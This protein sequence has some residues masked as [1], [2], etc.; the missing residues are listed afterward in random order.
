MLFNT[1]TFPF[2][3]EG[4]EAARAW[5][6]W[7]MRKETYK[8]SAMLIS[9]VAIIAISSGATAASMGAVEDSLIKAFM[10]SKA[11]GL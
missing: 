7:Y 5:K 8:L 9:Y 2:T 1:K 6:P 10:S 4:M 11:V 3:K